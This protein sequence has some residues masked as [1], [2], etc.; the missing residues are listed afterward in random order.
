MH[1]L[2]PTQYPS[3]KS[4]SMTPGISPPSVSISHQFHINLATAS[5]ELPSK[6]TEKGN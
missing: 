1:H 2:P 5:S 4:S 3:P 6:I